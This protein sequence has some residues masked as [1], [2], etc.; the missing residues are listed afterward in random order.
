MFDTNE[1]FSSFA[2]RDPDRAKKFYTETLGL[3]VEPVEGMEDE[4]L[5][6]L[7]LGN[8]TA[9]LVYPKPNHTPASFTVLNFTVENI[10]ATVDELTQRGV[11]FVRYPE[12]DQDDKGIA[13]GTPQVAWF[14]DPSGNTIGII[15]DS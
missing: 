14:T 4:G 15:Q 7:T 9:I 1:A 6:T 10:D 5:Q 12:F 8:G 3:S 2:V 11:E 13:R